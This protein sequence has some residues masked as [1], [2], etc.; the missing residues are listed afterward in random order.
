MKRK[1]QIFEEERMEI[2]PIVKISTSLLPNTNDG[3]IFAVVL[4]LDIVISR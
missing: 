1:L 2:N 4:Y 3:H